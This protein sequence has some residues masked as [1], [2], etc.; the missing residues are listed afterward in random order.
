MAYPIHQKDEYKK[1][2][3]I[4]SHANFIPL[5]TPN[6]WSTLNP[7]SIYVN[8]DFSQPEEVIIDTIKS[9]KKI[10]DNNEH[11]YLTAKAHE[12]YSGNFVSTPSEFI[13]FLKSKEKL[14]TYEEKLTDIIYIFDC[15]KIHLP[16]KHI[17]NNLY[18]YYVDKKES[19]SL[20]DTLRSRISDLKKSIQKYIID[21]SE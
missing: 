7:K 5:L 10:I 1:M 18:D 2:R 3:M 20:Y 9:I 17:Q 8:I 19:E 14:F 12:I 21:E 15:I 11:S 13:E 16:N 6:F 4:L